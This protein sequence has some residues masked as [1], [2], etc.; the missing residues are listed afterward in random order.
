MSDRDK[1][2]LP[3][4]QEEIT[5]AKN[6]ICV[7]HLVK[8]A[9]NETRSVTLQIEGLIPKAAKAY[10]ELNFLRVMD[11]IKMLSP[12]VYDYLGKIEPATWSRSHA[13]VSRYGHIITNI[14]ESFNQLFTEIRDM[15]IIP[16]IKAINLW[17]IT[18]YAKKLKLATSQHT[19]E[20]WFGNT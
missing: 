11:E 13:D 12:S 5:Y 14:S 20:K 6:T 19:N 4:L 18:N 10:T 3:A 7:N 17:T 15:S 16:A 9:K 8:N 1:G 2:L